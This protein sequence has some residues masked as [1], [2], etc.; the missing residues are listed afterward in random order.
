MGIS[1]KLLRWQELEPGLI[2][3]TPGNA[4]QNRTGDWRTK[5]PQVDTGKC[6]SCGVCFIY[7]PD[8]AISMKPDKSFGADLFFCKGCGICAKECFTGCIVMIPEEE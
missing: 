3:R 6:I 8:M 7:C 1:S 4:R 2:I 5:R